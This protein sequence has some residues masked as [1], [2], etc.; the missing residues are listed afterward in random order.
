MKQQ[1]QAAVQQQQAMQ[2]VAQEQAVYQ[3]QQQM[4]VQIV[5]QQENASSS[6]TNARPSSSTTA[7]VCLRQSCSP[8]A[9]SGGG[10]TA[11]RGCSCAHPAIS[12]SCY[13]GSNQTEITLDAVQM[14]QIKQMAQAKAEAAAMQQAK[15]QL[16]D[17]QAAQ[18]GQEMA[19]NRALTPTI[20]NDVQDVVDISD[21]WRKMDTDSRS[22]SLLIDNQAKA[23]TVSE[24]IGRFAKQGTKIRNSPDVYVQMIDSMAMQS[25][26]LLTRPFK[27]LLQLAAVMQYDYDNGLNKDDLARKMLGEKL[28]LSNRKRLEAPKEH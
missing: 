4:A 27:D 24:Y 22:W 10:S 12:T 25:P 26:E 14:A 19:Q 1:M 2:M 3:A 13:P 9:G 23:A 6:A 5:Q 15:G 11:G 17:F 16:Q 20:S 28:Y 21:V 7:G 8:G 18:M